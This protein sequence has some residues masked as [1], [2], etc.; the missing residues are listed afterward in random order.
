MI[1][2][3]FLYFGLP[4]IGVRLDG[5]TCAILGLSFLGGGYMAEAFRGGL[6]AVGKSQIESGL[7]LGLGRAGLIRFVVLPQALA[8]ALPA[9]SA[10][11]I[12]LIKETSVFSVVALA[13]ITYVANDL[14]IDGHSNEINLLM[15]LSYL[16]LVLPVSVL[17]GRLE[18]RL[19]HA[20][21]SG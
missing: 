8:V 4:R 20:G 9:L 7:C 3:F 13:D 1:Q 19:R 18:R 2:L 21:F 5:V 16:V 11:V 15:V 17:L 14:M 6:E 12:F 10:N